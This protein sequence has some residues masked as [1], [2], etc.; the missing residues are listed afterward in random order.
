MFVAAAVVDLGY[1]ATAFAFAY[2]ARDARMLADVSS[3]GL[4]AEVGPT[5]K[6]GARAAFRSRSLSIAFTRNPKSSTYGLTVNSPSIAV[7]ARLEAASAPSP[8]TAVCGLGPGRTSV[9][10]KRALLSAS[11]YVSAG[12]QER[13]LEGGFGAYDYTH[14]LLPRRTRWNW[15]MLLGTTSEGDPIALNLVQGFMGEAECA[16]FTRAGVVG[17]PEGRFDFDPERPLEPW[18]V[19]TSDGETDLEFAPGAMHAER[20]NLVLVR[21]RFVQPVG[22]FSGTIGLGPRSVTIARALGVVE[23]QDVLW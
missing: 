21:S 1:S 22:T 5:A 11:G 6:E 8:I 18:R 9:T 2:D 23:D 15:A 16:A 12:G 17:L 14:G 13:S 10:E 7:G 19:R 20:K 3:L 4:S